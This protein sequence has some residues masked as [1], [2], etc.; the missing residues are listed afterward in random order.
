MYC[1]K[2]GFI[3]KHTVHRFS[4]FQFRR[5][6]SGVDFEQLLDAHLG[7]NLCGLQVFVAK[8]LLD[9]A[10]VRAAF[11]HVRGA[12]MPKQVAT[13]ISSDVGLFDVFGHLATEH[14][15][16]EGLTVAA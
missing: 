14:V 5:M 15:G 7:V 9:K 10:D 1:K 12:A 16:I 8:Q 3:C 13:A 2:T 11:E 4:F 6:C